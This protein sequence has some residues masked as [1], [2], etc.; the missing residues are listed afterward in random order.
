MLSMFPH[1]VCTLL[2]QCLSCYTLLSYLSSLLRPQLHLVYFCIFSTKSWVWHTLNKSLLSGEKNGEN[3]PALFC[4]FQC[5][6]LVYFFYSIL[7]IWMLLWIKKKKSFFHFLLVPNTQMQNF[8]ILS[9]LH[10]Y[11]AL[12]VLVAGLCI[13]QNFL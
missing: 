3:F 10:C 12:L 13:S 7:P 8:Y 2:P 1:V 9:P 5:T 6:G 4:S 11:T